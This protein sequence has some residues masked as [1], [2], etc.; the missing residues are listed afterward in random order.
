VHGIVCLITLWCYLLYHSIVSL[1]ERGIT[2]VGN[3][4]DTNSLPSFVLP[5][6]AWEFELQP[7]G[8][9]EFRV[10]EK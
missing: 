7:F 1:D 9:G 5:V 8:I 3:M 4:P 2:S 6:N 10:S